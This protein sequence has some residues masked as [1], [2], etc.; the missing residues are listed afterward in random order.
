MD[1]S[2]TPR[3]S[4]FQ[5]CL[6][7]WLA[8]EQDS[9]EE[10]LEEHPTPP[11]HEILRRLEETERLVAERDGEIQARNAE[12]LLLRSK[13]EAFKA[14]RRRPVAD[15]GVSAEVPLPMTPDVGEFRPIP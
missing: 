5:E 8:G 10:W 2:L 15:G 3:E 14:P 1:G 12:V 4:P 11:V 7:R 6:R 9:L 13:L